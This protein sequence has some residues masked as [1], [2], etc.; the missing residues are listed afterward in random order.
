LTALPEATVNLIADLVESDEPPA[1]A[2]TQLKARL[3]AAHSLTDYQKVEQLFALPPLGARRPSEMLAK[4]V[5]LCSR[6]QEDSV[7]FV[8]CLLH[9]LPRELRVLLTDVYNTDCCSL[10]IKADRLWS[11]NMKLAHDGGNA[12]ADGFMDGGPVVAAIQQSS[13]RAVVAVAVVDVSIAA[14]GS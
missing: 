12:V 1:D 4:I 9:R 14:G 11:H 13:N 5:R 6:G 2:Y 3:N 10:A 8:Y 7:F